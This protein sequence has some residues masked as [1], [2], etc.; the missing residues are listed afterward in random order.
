MRRP[1]VVI[2]THGPSWDESRSLEEQADWPA[3]AE[4]MDALA[5][6]GFITIGGPLEETPDTLLV[7]TARDTLEIELRLSADPWSRDGHL[8]VKDC[9]P[10]HVRLGS[11][12]G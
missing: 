6:E 12:V 7:I 1:F 5:A 8:T 10:W 4:F 3:H 11:L 2:R 9:R